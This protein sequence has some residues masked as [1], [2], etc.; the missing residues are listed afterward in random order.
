VN[1]YLA[2]ASVFAALRTLNVRPTRGMGQNFLVSGSVL[3]HIVEAAQLTP[4]DVVVEVGPGLGVL[5]WELLQHAGTVIAVELDRRLADRMRQ[6]F[7]AQYQKH[8]S[9]HIVQGDILDFPS[10]TLLSYQ[11]EQNN[12]QPDHHHYKVVANLP[13]AITSPV[14]RHFLEHIPRPQVMIVLMQWEVAQ[15]ITASPGKMS[16]L[17]HAVQLYAQPE[18]V[19][20]IP[21]DCFIPKPAVASALVRLVVHP[22]PVVDVDD[23]REFFHVIKAGFSQPRK[24][25]SNAFPAGLASLGWQ[26]GRDVAIC[27]LKCAGVSPDQRAETLS[28]NDWAAVHRALF[29]KL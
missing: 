17:A 20:Q 16:I 7:S 27:A 24:K 26:G 1:P 11:T 8:T 28:L 25:L 18:I 29:P 2:P 14:L 3:Q 9:L 22:T 15:R 12:N 5:T 4:H 6:E 19:R 10:A 13:Y 23:V 21:A